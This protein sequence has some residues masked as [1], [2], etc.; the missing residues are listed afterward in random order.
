ML[1]RSSM[2]FNR[3]DSEQGM[4]GQTWQDKVAPAVPIIKYVVLITGI[5]LVF[6]F[7]IRPLVRN[8][9][10]NTHGIKEN[11]QPQIPSDTG[12]SVSLSGSSPTLSLSQ[13]ENKSLNE[14]DLAKQ[15]A[16]ADSKKFA[17][18]LRNWLK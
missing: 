8:M 12:V 2:P 13:F 7:I 16:G 18:L 3:P 10:N 1:F 14:M 11:M 17:E 5:L 6:L 4:T 15:L 9:I